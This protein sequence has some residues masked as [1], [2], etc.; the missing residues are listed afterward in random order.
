MTHIPRAHSVDAADPVYQALVGRIDI[1]LDGKLQQHVT[2]YDMDAG[3]VV[4]AVLDDEGRMQA[5]AERDA[6]LVE[7]VTGRVEVRQRHSAAN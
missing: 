2:A 7:Q 5:N 1:M 6:L 3:Y 4:R